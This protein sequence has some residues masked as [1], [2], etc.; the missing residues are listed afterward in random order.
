MHITLNWS[1]EGTTIYVQMANDAAYIRAVGAPSTER[2]VFVSEDGVFLSIETTPAMDLFDT[3]IKVQ[4]NVVFGYPAIMVW[5]R[6]LRASN[7]VL[8]HVASIG[9]DY[10]LKVLLTN[11]V[12]SMLVTGFEVYCEDRFVEMAEEGRTAD[13]DLLSKKLLTKQAKDGNVASEIRDQALRAGIPFIEAFVK[14]N[15]IN[16]QSLTECKEAYKA[17]FGIRF[18]QM[19]LPNTVLE[20]VRRY[21]H[22][23]HRIIHVSPY[24]ADFNESQTDV[25]PIFAGVE[26]AGSAT[27]VFDTFVKALHARSL[28]VPGPSG[29]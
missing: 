26:L 9:D 28:Q 7:M 24:I 27:K 13:E 19:G 15:R 29:A 17:A 3:F 6:V 5:E 23:R 18:G 16:F 2:R 8:D 20:Q 4:G 22:Y 14:D 11:Q 25:T 1:H 21:L 10:M 12:L